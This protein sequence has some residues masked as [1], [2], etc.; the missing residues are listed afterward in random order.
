MRNYFLFVALVFCTV[1]PYMIQS[2]TTASNYLVST[3]GGNTAGAE[4]K[5]TLD[6]KLTVLDQRIDNAGAAPQLE[7]LTLVKVDYLAPQKREE[8][9]IW[10]PYSN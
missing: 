7:E 8:R 2:Q 1:N 3:N 10:V 4:L 6:N 5:S 9:I